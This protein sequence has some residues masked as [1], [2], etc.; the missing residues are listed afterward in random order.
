MKK[1][2]LILSAIAA[3]TAVGVAQTVPSHEKYV[4]L[5][6]S[7]I[8]WENAYGKWEEGT[9]LYNDDADAAENENF[10]ISRVKPRKR[11]TFTPTQVKEGL[12]PGRKLIWWCPINESGWNAIPSYF[13]NG[14][15]F[16][17]W[18]YTDIYGN[19]TASIAQVPA[20]FT[21]IC[22]KN[23][24]TTGCVG[25]I[26]WNTVPDP[27]NPNDPNGGPMV[28][29]V[30]NNGSDK[31][32]K[33]LRYYGIDG[34][35]WN[36]EFSWSKLDRNKFKTVMGECY[37]NAAAYG[38][39]TFNNAWYN[40][41]TSGGGVSKRSYFG[42]DNSEWFH[43]NNKIVS[44]MIFL[45][46][47]WGAS[48]LATSQTT[49][50]SFP[51]RSSFDIYGG[52]DFQGTSSASWVALQNYDISVGIWGAHDTNMMFIN[53]GENGSEPIQR[54]QTYQLISENVFTGSSYNPVNTPPITDLLSHTSGEKRFHG[55]SSFIAERSSLTCD[56]LADDPFVT[57][58]NVGNGQFFNVNGETTFKQDWYNIGIQDYLPTWRWWWT[59][60]FMGK[61]KTDVSEDLTAEFYWKDAW[62]AGSCLS[63]SGKTDAAYL[64]LFKTK[65]ATAASGDYITIRYKVLSGSG[66]LAW[67]CSVES[68]PKTEVAATIKNNM[69][70]TGEWVEVRT[71]ISSGRN[72]LKVHN[73]V[74]ALIGL[75]FTNTSSD[76]KVLI[77]EMTVTRG[78]SPTPEA[79]VIEKTK[80]LS[81]NY[82]GA[83]MKVIFKMNSSKAAPVYNADVNT[84]YFKIYTR[85]EGSDPVVCTA[86]T[87]WASYVVGAPYDKEQGGKMQIGVSAVSLDGKNESPISWSELINI[88]E[89]SIIEGVSID[90]PIIKPGE[91][92]T[93]KYDDPNHPASK[94][95]I[96][97]ATTGALEYTENN[98]LSIT[99]SLPAIGLYDVKITNP[100]GK[101]SY[102]RGI[103]QISPESTGA[104]PTIGDFTADKMN[105]NQDEK[106]NLSYMATRLGEGKVSRAVKIE[107]PGA[108]HI[109]NMLSGRP[110]TYM[111]WFR[112]DFI[113][114]N[115]QGTNLINKLKWGDTWPHG[116]WGDFWVI[117]RPKCDGLRET[118]SC[119][120]GGCTVFD[121]VHAEN[122]ISFNTYGW[123]E[124]NSPCSQMMSTGYSVDLKRWTHLT[125][126]CDA[127]NTQ[128]MY[129]N[130]KLVAGPYKLQHDKNGGNRANGD[131]YVGGSNT[132]KSGMIGM[133]D[134]FQIW[135]RVLSDAEVAEAMNGYEEGA[136]IPDGL[137][138]YYDF[139]KINPDGYTFPNRGKAG[140][141]KKAEYMKFNSDQTKLVPDNNQL[142]NPILNGSFEVKT[143]SV[144]IAKDATFHSVGGTLEDG[145]AEISYKASGEYKPQLKLENMWGSDSK[146]IDFIQVGPSGIEESVAEVLGVYPN[147]FTDFVNIMFTK[148]GV[149][150]VQIVAL[151]GKLIETKEL[152]VADG[153]GV[154][155][156]VNGDKGTYVLRILDERNI[157]VRTVK[158]IKK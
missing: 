12:N 103:I 70:P 71:P 34:I 2:V 57:Y 55:F 93:M 122:E 123:S 24:V 118:G 6:S 116:N 114:H 80:M 54:Q 137:V 124:H 9:P 41:T 97:N 85:Q 104:I 87:S 49:A 64:Q 154:R 113:S 19:W 152:S 5:G 82:K 66:S 7:S 105:V 3:Y 63:V 131:I 101:E 125:I 15:A 38:W 26:G 120:G 155:I 65:Y 8:K 110:Y 59:K 18:S 75:K 129:F 84:W 142:G 121:K 99:A 135:N 86:T 1:L 29:A 50:R 36:S 30:Y 53:Q 58:F 115:Q 136:T 149:Y 22:H 107:D 60:N 44:D 42:S 156:D 96:V 91:T 11:F 138:G 56:N 140:A 62:F 20:A 141:D 89:P 72:G 21:D 134:D 151:D 100:D 117:L 109:P 61:T 126:T 147:P 16:T 17:M 45:D 119:E 83:D 13:F 128:K 48:S 79:P 67:A 46:Y 68:A 146:T 10:F 106:I 73:D 88:P 40:L 27:N 98:A 31:L 108:I 32:L 148:A 158:V 23:G 33:Y 51:G 111:M 76:F 94:W 77:G 139:E 25:A 153:E 90:K 35:G 132:Y 74:L 130:G 81:Y 69:Q 4:R 144:W 47:G 102:T 150:T 112:M 133:L 92:F 145:K 143:D 157:A 95:E 39:P 52:M 14:E 78:T 28:A 127:E 43:Y 37:T